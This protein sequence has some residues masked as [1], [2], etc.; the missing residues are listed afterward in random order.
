[1]SSCSFMLGYTY[2]TSFCPSSPTSS[3]SLPRVAS[4]SA[5]ISKKKEE[6]KPPSK[7]KKPV[8]KLRSN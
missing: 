5:S 2:S 4:S 1:M 8:T 7:R 3:K 6:S